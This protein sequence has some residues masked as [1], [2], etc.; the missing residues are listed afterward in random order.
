MNYEG[1]HFLLFDLMVIGPGNCNLIQFNF[2]E[3]PGYTFQVIGVII[4]T[5]YKKNV[6]IPAR[7]EQ[8]AVFQKT[9][10]SCI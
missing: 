6:F 3:F 4:L 7:D 2:P 1:N 8:A 5:I 10:V 9:K